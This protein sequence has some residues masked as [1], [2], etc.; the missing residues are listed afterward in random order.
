[1]INVAESIFIIVFGTL[2]HFIFEWSGHRKWA[3]ML[4]AVNESTWEHIKLTIYPAFVLLA[5]EAAF[6]GLSRTAVIAR[7]AGMAV[8]MV[9]VPAL[10][11]GYTA[12]T[13]KNWL[14][15]DI[16]CF[17]LSV[18][19]GSAMRGLV[20]ESGTESVALFVISLTGL[21]A[22]LVMYLTFSYRPPFIFLFKDP[23][24]GGYGPTGHGCHTHF[25]NSKIV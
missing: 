15:S 18:L 9:A 11:Y 5:A 10:F 23:V 17:I 20:L 7:F 1:M 16:I 4:F 2:G 8:T 3:G 12:I 13:K 6:S 21:A 24:S 19:A 14:W 22:I 25:H